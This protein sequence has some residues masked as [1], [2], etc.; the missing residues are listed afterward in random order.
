MGVREKPLNPIKLALV[1]G[2]SFVARCNPLDL[3]HTQEILEKAIKHKGFAFIEMVQKCLIF[4]TNMNELDK[5]MYK[6]DNKTDMGKAMKLA[7]EWDYNSR[8]GKI[9]IGIFYQE[10]KET[11]EERYF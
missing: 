2:A 7:S 1:S 3:K 10:Q 11:L 4:N 6:I 8:K 9:P 5:F